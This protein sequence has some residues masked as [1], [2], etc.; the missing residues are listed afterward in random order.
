MGDLYMTAVGFLKA[1]LDLGRTFA[2]IAESTSDND[3]FSRNRD[4][5]KEAIRTIEHFLG[6]IHLSQADFAYLQE[7]VV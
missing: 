4:S 7:G 5:T 2:S 6:T 3:K 1:E